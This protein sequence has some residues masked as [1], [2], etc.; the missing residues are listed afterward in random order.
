MENLFS[1][2][3]LREETV[4]HAIF[5]RSLAGGVD[6]VLGYRLESVTITDPAA[7][8]ISG[9]TEH[10]ILDHTGHDGD[11]VEGAVFQITEAEL[12]LADSYEDAAYKRVLAPLRSGGEAW[13]YVRA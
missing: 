12:S 2:G 10:L 3:T 6:A 1:Y 5:G 4:Q 7:I 8:A 11:R 13:V 9:K